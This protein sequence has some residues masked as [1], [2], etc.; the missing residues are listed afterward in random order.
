MNSV[1]LAGRLIKDPAVYD[2]CCKFTIVQKSKYKDKE[3]EFFNITTFDSVANTCSQYLK[4]GRLVC[5]RGRLH[6]NKYTDKNNEEQR[7]VE[8]LCDTVDF[9]DNPRQKEFNPDLPVASCSE[10]DLTDKIQNN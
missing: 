8:I 6:I 5:V 3:D 1:I 10:Q 4:K 9:M 7:T 2:R